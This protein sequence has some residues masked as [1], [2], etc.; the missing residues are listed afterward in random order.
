M[1]TGTGFGH[2]VLVLWRRAWLILLIVALCSGATFYINRLS[3][4]VYEASAL[5]QVHDAGASNN[6]VFTDQALAQS[7]ALL[8]N[9]A[10]VLQ[11]VAK[12]IPRVTVQ[13]LQTT[14]SDSPLDNTQIIQ[15][16]ASAKNP[17]LAAQIANAVVNAFIALQ[18]DVIAARQVVDND[19]TDLL[20]L[21][22]DHADQG[23]I[24]H[25]QDILSNDQIN[26]TSL[27]TNYNQVQQQLLQASNTL[28]IVQLATPPGAPISPRTL[29][30]T[31]VAA[32]LSLLLMLV[33]VLLLDW[34]DTTVKTPEDI[35]QMTG[36][37]ALGS[38]PLCKG[39]GGKNASLTPLVENSAL[40][41][42]FVGIST[43]VTMVNN[44]GSSIVVTGLHTRC[45][46]STVAANLA[47][48]LARSGV[49]VL[50][51]DANIRKAALHEVLQNTNK[52]GLTTTLADDSILQDI[53]GSQMHT[54]LTQWR[55]RIPHLW[56]LPA[57]PMPA[58]QKPIMRS[59]VIPALLKRLLQPNPDSGITGP[60][61]FVDIVIF[62]APPLGEDTDTLAIASFTDAAILVIE[63]GKEQAIMLRKA[64]H[65]LNR[66]G[67]SLLGVVVNRQT[68]KQ[69]PYF[70]VSRYR[71]PVYPVDDEKRE[72][73]LAT[74]F[75]PASYEEPVVEPQEKQPAFTAKP[76]LPA[77]TPRSIASVRPGPKRLFNTPG[78]GN[79]A[80]NHKG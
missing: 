47:I 69:H 72:R 66:L 57:G 2:Y 51:I 15:V 77:I 29:V 54:W 28:S 10:D 41:Q 23:R 13:Q 64:Q 42:A 16:R 9:Q 14:V 68:P 62:D 37:T 22:T 75:A 52:Q 70:Y 63:A 58:Q 21:Q 1:F 53:S 76:M 55:T 19:Q 5:I 27:Q 61:S 50:L 33:F 25:Q 46:T 71:Q 59:P 43:N 35:E 78:V 32:A 3:P 4:P 12:K 6:N 30:N 18:K 31:L 44:G 39:R 34:M 26:Y 48:S 56:F 60:P 17:A 11:V 74:R 20:A 8:V 65:M 45:G 40:D 49:R 73:P 38:V 79:E 24:T 80:N 7:Y 67:S 36:F